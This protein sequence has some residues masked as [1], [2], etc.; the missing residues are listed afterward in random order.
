MHTPFLMNLSML[1][2]DNEPTFL[3]FMRAFIQSHGGIFFGATDIKN[4]LQLITNHQ[5]DVL[6]SDIRLNGDGSGFDLVDEIS[7]VDPDLTIILITGCYDDDMVP[8]LI[9]KQVYAFLTKPSLDTLAMGLLLLQAARNTRSARRNRWVASGLRNNIEKIQAER[10]QMFFDTLRSLSKALEQKDEYTRNHS[11]MVAL[12]SEKLC[13]EL[14][15]G[16]TEELIADI[17]VAG[18]LHDIGKIGIRDDIL[19]KP[20]N[21]TEAEY[22]TIKTHAEFSYQIVKPVDNDGLISSYVLHHHERWNGEGYP[23]RLR[24]T[25][26]P[27]GARILAV[28]DTYNALTSNRPY[29]LAKQKEYALGIIKEGAGIMFDSDIVDALVR[30]IRTG[31]ENG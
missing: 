5:F 9:T 19:F 18:R 11:E 7:Q 4:S 1:V 20:T 12:L 16:I 10:D 31:R 8:L 24:E 3:E 26:I 29:R 28:A 13:L 30:L 23:H 27:L 14:T 25:G 2:V 6:L 15:N 21:L 17:L 22:E